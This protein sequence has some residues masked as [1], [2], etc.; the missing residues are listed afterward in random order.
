M[1]SQRLRLE[2]LDGDLGPA[3]VEDDRRKSHGRA[4]PGLDQLAANPTGDPPP[5]EATELLV[6]RTPR[7]KRPIHRE[8]E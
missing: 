1:L 8:P 4:P 5:R 3:G 7:R 6:V 2:H